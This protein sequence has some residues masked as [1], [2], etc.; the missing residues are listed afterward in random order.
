MKSDLCTKLLRLGKH[1]ESRRSLPVQ[2]MATREPFEEEKTT[3]RRGP[4]ESLDGLKITVADT[5]SNQCER[6]AV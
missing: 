2:H 4:G 5:L 3:L 6:L 1:V